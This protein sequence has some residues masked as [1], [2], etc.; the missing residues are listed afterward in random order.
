MI[1]RQAKIL[2]ID[3]G[4]INRRFV[5]AILQEEG[6]HPIYAENGSD[7]LIMVLK[8]QPDLI[9]LDIMMPGMSGFEVCK[10][11]KASQDTQDIPVIFLSTKSD[12]EDVVTGFEMG[13]ADY[14]V[15]P[16]QAGELLARVKTQVK[17]KTLQHDLERAVEIRTME[18]QATNEELFETHND[19]TFVHTK[20]QE[21]YLEMIRRLARAA[22]F[23]DN[24]TGMHIFRMSNYS[25][26]LG[27]AAGLNEQECR[28][29][30]HASTM[31]DVGKIGIPDAILL[32][33]GKLTSDE[34]QTM[35]EHCEIGKKLLSDINSNVVNMAASIA[36]SHHEKWNGR[37]YPYGLKGE[38]IPLE[39]RIA[40]IVDVFDAL[41]SERPYKKPWSVEDAVALLIEEKGEH[42]D[43]RLVDLFV[44]NLPEV[45]A[46]REKFE[47]PN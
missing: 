12:S 46:V 15:K 25:A 10:K 24:E 7:G 40:G 41:V 14:I 1:D 42:F 6:Y 45:L 20:L 31:H 36:V 43:A 28:S 9:L 18:L 47:D 5:G 35:K 30:L 29:L 32:K 22:D 17:L 33:P 8:E 37:G 19:L 3:D 2:V 21:V 23:R 39:G 38:E 44:D 13:A 11:L 34:F 27:K 16:F 4:M 26:I